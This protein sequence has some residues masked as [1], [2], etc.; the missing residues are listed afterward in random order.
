M[1]WQLSQNSK[2][3]KAYDV[4]KRYFVVSALQDS[5][6]GRTMHLLGRIIFL[7]SFPVLSQCSDPCIT[8]GVLR[9]RFRSTNYQIKRGDPALCDNTLKIG[10]YRFFGGNMP[11]SK[12][13]PY[14]C[15][16]I[17]PI[18][19][20]GTHPTVAD[21]I[22]NRKACVNFMGRRKGCFIAIPIRV[23]NCS[24][25]YVYYLKPASGCYMAYCAG[26]LF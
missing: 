13:D 8:H 14:H 5:N 10:W 18:W 4:L 1:N 15:G 11:E 12:I 20:N 26:K 21:G 25:F 23:K 22:V 16:T 2:L 6:L 9:N 3:I 19:M 24:G 17:A 7:L